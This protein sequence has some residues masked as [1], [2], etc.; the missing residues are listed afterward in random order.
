MA[1]PDVLEFD[2]AM[3]SALDDVLRLI[4]DLRGQL[5]SAEKS[6]HDMRAE[7]EEGKPVTMRINAGG[8]VQGLGNQLDRHVGKLL[9]LTLAQNWR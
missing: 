2:F 5:D 6:A 1:T 3:D 4:A 8:I 9:V 7:H